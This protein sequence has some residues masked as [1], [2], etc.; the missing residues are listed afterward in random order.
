MGICRSS[1]ARK[2]GR[3]G[4]VLD[5]R[6]LVCVDIMKLF[7]FPGPFRISFRTQTQNRRKVGPFLRYT[8]Y[9][10]LHFVFVKEYCG[11][12]AIP[13]LVGYSNS[14]SNSSSNS[15]NSS[16]SNGSSNSNSNS[17]SN[18]NNNSNSNSN[19]SSSSNSNSNSNSNPFITST[20]TLCL[21]R[22]DEVQYS[23]VPYV[24]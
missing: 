8:A 18:N 19:S 6:Q 13:F 1:S 5:F 15:N 20:R 2:R 7:R 21:Y 12:A 22:R 14:N 11:V 10:I 23:T 3:D 9:C 16:S 17:S 24:Q 4:A